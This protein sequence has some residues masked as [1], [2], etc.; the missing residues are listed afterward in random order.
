MAVVAT[1]SR[2]SPPPRAPAARCVGNS[3]RI[4]LYNYLLS[5]AGLQGSQLTKIEHTTLGSLQLASL[6]M[7]DTVLVSIEHST[8]WDQL[9]ED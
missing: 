8:W 9:A 3:Q 7:V 6:E 4:K 1:W 2:R 5:H